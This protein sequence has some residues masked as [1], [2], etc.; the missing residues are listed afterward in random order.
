MLKNLI[1]L[2]SEDDKIARPTSRLMTI[3]RCIIGQTKRQNEQSSDFLNQ[4]QCQHKVD[5]AENE[6]DKI[7]H[8]K[9]QNAWKQTKCGKCAKIGPY[10]FQTKL[11]KLKTED[12]KNNII[13][14]SKMTCGTKGTI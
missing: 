12:D 2:E 5:K 4:R 14:E 11:T 1:Q 13:P 8:Q 10:C 3:K 9:L 6:D 7:D